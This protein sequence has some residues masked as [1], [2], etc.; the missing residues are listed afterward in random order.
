MTAQEITDCLAE[1]DG[2]LDES[3]RPRVGPNPYDEKWAEAL[4]EAIEI[5]KDS[6]YRPDK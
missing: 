4:A 6:K 3:M 5:I 2:F 1:I